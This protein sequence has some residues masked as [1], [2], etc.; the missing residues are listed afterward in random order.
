MYEKDHSRLDGL[1]DKRFPSG[2]EA[3]APAPL[4]FPILAA[5]VLVRGKLFWPAT[6]SL[7][8]DPKAGLSPPYFDAWLSSMLS[9]PTV[10]RDK[11]LHQSPV[12]SL[13]AAKEN[14]G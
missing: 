7:H 12:F 14:K 11:L 3:E 13:I 2:E 1:L 4:L 5:F 6:S 10:Q 9:V 8:G